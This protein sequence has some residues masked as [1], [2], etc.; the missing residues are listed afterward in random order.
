M[1]RPDA[2]GSSR[3]RSRRFLRGALLAFW[4]PATGALAASP[5]DVAGT[6]PSDPQA[7]DESNGLDEAPPAA[8]SGIPASPGAP[9]AGP[10][11]GDDRE[12]DLDALSSELEASRADD[13]DPL[14]SLNRHVLD[15]N[16]GVDAVLLDPLTDAYTFLVPDLARQSVRNA[17]ANLGSPVIL[18]ND[19]LQLEGK[20]AFVTT[21]R[22]LINS[23]MGMGGLFDAAASMGLEPH[24][25]NFSETL[26]VAGVPRG[27]YL[28]LPLLGPT[29]VRD[30]FGTLV[31]LAMSPQVYI[32]PV[33]SVVI[34]TGGDGFSLR[35]RHAEDL[36]ALR[37]TSV[38]YYAALRSAY[39]DQR[40]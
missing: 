4:L 11:D 1:T 32:L 2:R 37:D 9:P 26:S 28:V 15:L 35:E 7:C 19:L 18:V 21:A 8:E 10:E 31:D 6:P 33:T 13:S 24:V 20:D 17:F 5:A 22:F 27:P 25:S 29:T 14:E 34:V 36:E 30:S 12:A 16:H 23:T 3:A 38:D 39:L 40:R